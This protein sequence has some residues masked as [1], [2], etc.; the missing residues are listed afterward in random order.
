[1]ISYF[2]NLSLR[3]LII[4]SVASFSRATLVSAE[5]EFNRLFNE[6]DIVGEWEQYEVL[7]SSE[8]RLIEDY[9]ATMEEFPDP[10]V[11]KGEVPCETKK[12]KENNCK[13][14]APLN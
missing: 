9:L 3:L 12:G 8:A 5:D 6:F 2:N 1:M 13:C 7:D 11:L 14:P 4:L 10:S